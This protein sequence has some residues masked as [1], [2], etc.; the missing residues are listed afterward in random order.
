MDVYESLLWKG[1]KLDTGLFFCPCELLQ[2]KMSINMNEVQNILQKVLLKKRKRCVGRLFYNITEYA[3]ITKTNKQKKQSFVM[4]LCLS[5]IMTPGH[6]FD[7]N[8]QE[9]LC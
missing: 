2:C 5:V 1:W 6:P 7:F 4:R 3:K 9:K 8:P